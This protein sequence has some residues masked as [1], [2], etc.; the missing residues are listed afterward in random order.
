MQQVV[1]CVN[2]GAPNASG[3]QFCTTCGTRLARATP[4]QVSPETQLTPKTTAAQFKPVAVPQNF[5]LLR[6]AAPVFRIVGWVVLAGG[7]VGT[8][9]MALLMAQGALTEFARLLG[10][11]AGVLGLGAAAAAVPLMVIAVGVTGS[12]LLGIGML[13]F[14]DLC[15]AVGDVEE[16]S[17]NQQ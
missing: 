9:A 10:S 17:R 5:Q 1:A 12:L 2:C 15:T 6:I 8:V 16:R 11:L 13:A 7:S 4:Q 14:A 3:Q